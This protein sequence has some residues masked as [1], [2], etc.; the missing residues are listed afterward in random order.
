[1]PQKDSHYEFSRSFIILSKDGLLVQNGQK[2]ILHEDHADEEIAVNPIGK[3]MMYC[4]PSYYGLKNTSLYFQNGF[5][6]QTQDIL[7]AHLQRR[8]ILI[9]F[10][11]VIGKFLINFC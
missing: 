3:F 10:L 5:R 6:I 1:M 7:K 8:M 2:V 9:F 4:N 11:M